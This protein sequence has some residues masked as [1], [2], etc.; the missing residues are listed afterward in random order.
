MLRG[1][2]VHADASVRC[3]L[4]DPYVVGAVKKVYDI[5]TAIRQYYRLRP[6][7]LR[8]ADFTRIKKAARYEML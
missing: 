1:G 7:G 4:V 8:K 3:T 5:I 2:K 6:E